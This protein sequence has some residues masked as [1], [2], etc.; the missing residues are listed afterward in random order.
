MAKTVVGLFDDAS[1]KQVESELR[2]A[3][4]SKGDVN[5]RTKNHNGSEKDLD[6]IGIPRDDARRYIQGM[7]RG[8][9]LVTVRADD[10]EASK[11]AAI[12]DRAEAG[13]TRGRKSPPPATAQSQGARTAKSGDEVIPV[14]EE[15]L[16]IGKRQVEGS[17]GVRVFAHVV[18]EPVEESVK[19]REE[20]VRVER[21]PVDRPATEKDLA[22]AQSGGTIEMTERSE[23]AVVGK[24]AHV[25][26]EVRV[27]KDVAE[28][29]E[30]V[31][32][33]LRHTEVDVEPIRGGEKPSMGSGWEA[34]SRDFRG[35]FDRT[36]ASQPDAR[37]ESYEPAYRRGHA[38]AA[39]RRYSGR[40]WSAIETDARSD[41]ERDN[42]GTWE[43]MK[44]AMRHAYDRARGNKAQPRHA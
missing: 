27:G 2:S 30:K 41:W 11:A 29:T 9:T 18:E 3:G 5:L 38:L 28:R 44:G 1:A 31:R 7:D 16:E 40:D 36:Y 32:E 26:E 42:P 35:H 21:T 37:W 14:V 22:Q 6:K 15:Q 20:R 24:S 13:M 23:R 10:A 39:D 34:V 17:G 43:R 19:L 25:V 33:T 8:S 4:F 12:M